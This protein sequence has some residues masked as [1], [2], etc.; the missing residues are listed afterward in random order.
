MR[1]AEPG[2]IKAWMMQS[3]DLENGEDELEVVKQR[4]LWG[5]RKNRGV[6]RGNS[7]TYG[8]KRR[9]NESVGAA[10][11]RCDGEEKSINP[12]IPAPR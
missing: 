8:Q 7:D 1:K 11:R 12:V 3:R 4:S 2:S 10:K 9:R 5:L 6:M